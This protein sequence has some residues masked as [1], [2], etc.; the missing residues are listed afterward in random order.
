[1]HTTAN[2]AA[3]KAFEMLHDKVNFMHSL[4]STFTSLEAAST[5]T[6]LRSLSSRLHSHENDHVVD[7]IACS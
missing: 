4:I 6:S 7:V 5:G 3:T 1:M 2:L